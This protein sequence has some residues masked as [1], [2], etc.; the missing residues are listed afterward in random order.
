MLEAIQESCS[1]SVSSNV[2]GP[3]SV[4]TVTSSSVSIYRVFLQDLSGLLSLKER[5][6]ESKRVL[7]LRNYAEPAINSDTLGLNK[8]PWQLQDVC[9][10]TCDNL[11]MYRHKYMHIGTCTC[12]RTYMYWH[13]G[14]IPAAAED[15]LLPLARAFGKCKDVATVPLLKL[16]FQE[17]KLKAEAPGPM[18]STACL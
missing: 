1:I 15:M 8:A 11:Q 14:D 18:S 3:R 6:T 9:I 7:L 12:I 16:F 2:V 17:Y 4:G 5:I 13:T 10:H